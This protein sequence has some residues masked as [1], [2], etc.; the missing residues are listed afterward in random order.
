MISADD[1]Q[2]LLLEGSI[3]TIIEEHLLVGEPYVFRRA[4]TAYARVRQQLAR[5]LAVPEDSVLLVGS[6]QLGFSISPDGFPRRFNAKSDLDFVIIDQTLF[7][8]VWNT[9]LTWHY[10]LRYALEGGDRTWA[11]QRR[12]DVFWGWI[13]PDRITIPWRPCPP[14]LIPLRDLGTTWFQAFQRLSLLPE[15]STRP[16]S[17][18]LYRSREHA[19]MYHRDGLR[20]LKMKLERGFDA[21]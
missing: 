12:D 4:P 14:P 2:S 13:S 20:R 8:S 5:E 7:D 16:A 10:P 17:G 6:G 3:E 21:I 15:V 19:M 1:F 18:R 9:L 11:L